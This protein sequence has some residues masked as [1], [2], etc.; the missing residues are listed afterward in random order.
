MD[1]MTDELDGVASLLA[2]AKLAATFSDPAERRRLREA[3]GYSLEQVA[4][5][6][7]VRNRQTIANWESGAMP[8]SSP[9]RGAYLR[10]LEGLAQIHP[11]PTPPTA[12]DPEPHAEAAPRPPAAPRRTESPVAR[13]ARAGH[14]RHQATR[15][16]K[17]ADQAAQA[18][19]EMVTGAVEDELDKAQGDAEA[20]MDKLSKRAIPDVMRLFAETRAGARYE[21]TAYPALPDILHKPSKKDP[22]L[23]WEARPSWV[24][25]AYRRHPDGELRVTALDVNAA[26]L[27]ALKCH[28]PIGRL[29]HS[30]D[31]DY[32]KTRAGIH[33][34]TPP[35][36]RHPDLPNPLGDREEPGPLWITTATLRL[37][38]RLA[39]PKH[40]LLEAPVIH[41]SWTSSATENFLDALRQVLAAVRTD[42]LEQDDYV[43]LHYIKMMYAKLV[44][45]MGESTDNRD[46]T[47]PDWMHNIRSQAFANLYGRALKAHQAGLTVISVMGT[48]ELHVAGDVWAAT[49]QGKPLFTEGRGL[50]DMKV[51]TDRDGA[52]VHYTVT[53][54]AR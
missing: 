45:T 49:W 38:L 12:A 52:P 43:T 34:I 7:G 5:A 8:S 51:K 30:A 50:A 46:I 14:Q 16:T 25:P 48:D 28:L 39:G 4:K 24:N 3:A 42:A 11:A 29:E 20:A 23:V 31:G 6:V 21:Y 17:S 37:L 54:A 35:E 18:L 47:R 44:S 33:L 15:R 9:A 53:Q 27:S 40:Q 36:W 13:E 10:L 2:E 32:D 19:R 26:Y 41:E 22:D 1:V